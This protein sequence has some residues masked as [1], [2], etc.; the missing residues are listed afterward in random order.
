MNQSTIQLSELFKKNNILLDYNLD[1]IYIDKVKINKKNN[2]IQILLVSQEIV[3]EEILEYIKKII[4]ENIQGFDIDLEI[5]VIIADSKKIDIHYDSSDKFVVFD[6]ETTGLSP[7]ND[8]ITEIGAV[9][10]ENN[11]IVDIFS[12]LINPQII[13][14]RNIVDL[15]GISDYMVKDKPI[16]DEVLPEFERFIEGSILVAH[17]ASFDLGFINEQFSKIEKKLTNP[18]LDTL[19]LSRYLFPQLKSHKLNIVAKYL[20]VSLLNHHRAVDD[21]KATAEILLK[22]LNLIKKYNL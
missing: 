20:N 7:T 14:P 13:I 15:T 6:I 2:E 1:P 16:V 17:N 5:N 10:I 22:S 19:E 18:V 11:E 8:M 3:P 21:A 4:K 9:K 12:Q